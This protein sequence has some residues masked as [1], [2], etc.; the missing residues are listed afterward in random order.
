MSK[1]ECGNGCHMIQPYIE[2]AINQPHLL[3]H[4]HQSKGELSCSDCHERSEE[5]IAREKELYQSGRYEHP[6]YPRDFGNQFCF[7]CHDN[8][9]G[10][11]E[12]TAYFEDKKLINPHR[13]HNTR[14]ECS[15]CHKVH[16]RS[17]FTC[18]ECHK[19]DWK[20]VLPDWHIAE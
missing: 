5:K 9:E 1:E 16:R 20:S 4:K 6:F 2:N 7:E 8:Y 19:E 18:S 12:S 15:S 3:V 13:I 10:L 17:R 11:I 14:N